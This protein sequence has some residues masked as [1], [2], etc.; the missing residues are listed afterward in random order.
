[1]IEARD[2]RGTQLNSTVQRTKGLD[3]KRKKGENGPSDIAARFLFVEC[4]LSSNI[5]VS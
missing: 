2:R 3:F 4:C 5:G 1:M